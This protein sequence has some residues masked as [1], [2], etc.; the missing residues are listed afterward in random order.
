M[1]D[2]NFIGCMKPDVNSAVF[3]RGV[4]DILQLHEENRPSMLSLSFSFASV[5][6][7][8]PLGSTI[9]TSEHAIEGLH[10]IDSIT[11]EQAL[12]LFQRGHT[13]RKMIDCFKLM[14]NNPAEFCAERTFDELGNWTKLIHLLRPLNPAVGGDM[15]DAVTNIWKMLHGSGIPVIEL[16]ALL[17]R[18]SNE[19]CLVSCDCATY[20]QRAWCKHS[21]VIALDQGIVT[22]YPPLKDPRSLVPARKRG[23]PLQQTHPLSIDT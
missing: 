5:Q 10:K 18:E 6:H 4:N 13:G 17:Q 3:Y 19:Q 8:V 16:A 1:R 23:R 21:C 11:S 9:V 2:M 14:I 15:V 7:G 20:Q 22:S 12:G